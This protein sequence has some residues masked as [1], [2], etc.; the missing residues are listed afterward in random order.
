MGARAVRTVIARVLI[1]VLGPALGSAIVITAVTLTWV[2]SGETASAPRYADAAVVL[3]AA[4]WRGD[5]ASPALAQRA[6]AGARL[7]REG[8]VRWVFTTGGVGDRS[9]RSEGAV[10]R[11][12][13]INEGLAPADVIAE[14]ES[15]TTLENLA[16]VRTALREHGVRS[17]FVVSHAFHLARSVQIARDLG[18]D[19]WGIA[20]DVAGV[21][22]RWDERTQ[23]ESRLLVGY[24]FERMVLAPP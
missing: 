10:A 9:V 4:V 20:A 1:G 17:V 23:R 7:R 19:A 14:V 11:E 5:V 18:L 21:V 6:R 13:V 16:N 2:R 24:A 8:R 3:G 15:T 12:L 22:P